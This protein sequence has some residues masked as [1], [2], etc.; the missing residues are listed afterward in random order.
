MSDH[1]DRVKAMLFRC[2][3]HVPVE[4]TFVP[5]TWMRYR[6]ELDALV[7]R[8]PIVFGPDQPDRR[9][10]DAMAK[11]TYVEGRH[12]DAWGCTWRNVRTGMEA[13]V[14]G[15]PVAT[16]AAVRKLEPPAEDVGLPHGFM[17]MRLFY[18]RGFEE[19]MIDFAEEPPE[20]R[21]LIDTVLAYNV[22]Q[23]E[24]LLARHAEPIISSSNPRR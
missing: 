21:M 24:L 17:Y 7:R 5:A 20:L 6:D 16:R 8:H 23:M 2:P 18:L 15:H 22:R 1:D 19:L 14:T 11:D 3:E 9:D 13:L 10:Y 4:V 12:V